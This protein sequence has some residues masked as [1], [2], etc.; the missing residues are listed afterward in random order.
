MNISRK[1]FITSSA[2]AAAMASFKFSDL[3]ADPLGET[4]TQKPSISIFSKH[5]HWLD[6]TEMA[7]LAKDLGY[8][9]ID[10]TVRKDGHVS[11][12][13]VSTDLPKAVEIIRAAG[14]EVYTITTDIRTSEEPHT[15]SILKTAA[16]LGIKNYRMGWYAYT[17]NDMPTD[18]ANFNKQLKGLA[19]LN[20]QYQIHGDYENHTGRFG[21]AI[22]DLWLTLKDLNPLWTGCQFDIR[23][24]TVDGA[25][26]WSKNLELV[27]S[28]L[29]SITIKDFQWE[30][31]NN[32]WS[33]QNVPLGQGMV[34]FKQYFKL[35]KKQGFDKPISQHF[36]YPLGGAES[37]ARVLSTPK[38]EVIGHMRKDLQTLKNWLTA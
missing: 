17:G 11:P 14:L 37:G 10:L 21:G 32:K 12:E 24:A 22:W 8:D 38:E 3:M 7:K 16:A 6:Y 23:H 28:Y 34:D 2:I 19:V 27:Q 36:E 4:I 35:L 13:K 1:Q 20:E 33:V 30:K 29:G 31:K 25:E 15:K 9:G 26:A 18:L 5:L